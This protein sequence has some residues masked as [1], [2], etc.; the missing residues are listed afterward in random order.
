M[1]NIAAMMEGAE[2]RHARKHIVMARII[3]Y[4]SSVRRWLHL[5]RK[6]APPRRNG[7]YG[8]ASAPHRAWRVVTAAALMKR[9]VNE[10]ENAKKSSRILK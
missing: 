8:A 10:H 9:A 4:S 7:L 5:E 1:H 6:Q 3:H 2:A